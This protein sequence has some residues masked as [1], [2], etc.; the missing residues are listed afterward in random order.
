MDIL[1][2]QK[3]KHYYFCFTDHMC[4]TG[5]SNAFILVCDSIHREKRAAHD[6]DHDPT[7]PQTISHLTYP[8]DYD[9]TDLPPP[10]DHE[11]P[12]P[13][14]EP[15]DPP[16]DYEPPN[17]PLTPKPWTTL[18]GPPAPWTT[19][20]TPETMRHLTHSPLTKVGPECLAS[21]EWSVRNREECGREPWSVC[22]AMLFCYFSCFNDEM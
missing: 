18:H 3:R 2:S 6:I 16:S 8:P 15:T 1:S 4:S 17:L 5:E 22:F 9:S 11:P 19:W 21:L 13:D 20:L 14:H 12:D 7:D 10:L